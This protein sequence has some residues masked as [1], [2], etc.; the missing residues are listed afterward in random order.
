A[1]RADSVAVRRIGPGSSTRAITLGPV[2]ACR[3]RSADL[4]LPTRRG[5]AS[6]Q[7]G[8]PLRRPYSAAMRLSEPRYALNGDLHV[9]YRTVGEGP[10]DIVFVSN[11]FTNVE[12]LPLLPSIQPWLEAMVTLGRVIFFDQPGT[13]ISDPTTPDALATLEQ[14]ADSITVVLDAVGSDHAVLLAIDG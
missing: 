8:R 1:P 10:R 12:T 9:A 7:Q 5:A 13:G 11:W 6:P 14:W 4:C 2:L 3:S